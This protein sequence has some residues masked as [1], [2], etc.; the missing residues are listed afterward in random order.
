MIS[1]IFLIMYSNLSQ[2]GGYIKGLGASQC[3][4]VLSTIKKAEKNDVE[5]VSMMYTS[6]IQGY[7]SGISHDSSDQISR[8]KNVSKDSLYYSVINRCKNE[9]FHI[10]VYYLKFDFM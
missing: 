10:K 5:W 8:L 2:A 4:D 6:W 3:G 7:L 9:M 1:I